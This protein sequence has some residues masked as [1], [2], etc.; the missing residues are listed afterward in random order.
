MLEQNA[1]I[2]AIC[3]RRATVPWPA[4]EVA[5]SVGEI[6]LGNGWG[7]L[8]GGRGYAVPFP[9]VRAKPPSDLDAIAR[10]NTEISCP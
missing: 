7:R 5:G 9:D 2:V 6:F 3:L 4:D 1:S 8:G 10:G